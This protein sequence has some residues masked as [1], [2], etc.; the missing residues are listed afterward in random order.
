M[1]FLNKYY[2]TRGMQFWQPFQNFF[3]FRFELFLKNLLF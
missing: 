3:W 2:W 1:F